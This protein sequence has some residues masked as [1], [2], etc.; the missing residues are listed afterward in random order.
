MDDKKK[1]VCPECSND[2]ELDP[3]REYAVGDI[4]ECPTCGS[5]LEVSSLNEDG[6]LVVDII[7]EEK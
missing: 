4:L 3:A 7:E 6:S 5:E 1:V 2:V